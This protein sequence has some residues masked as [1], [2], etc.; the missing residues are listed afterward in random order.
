MGDNLREGLEGL[1]KIEGLSDILYV[2]IYWT[3]VVFVLLFTAY[4]I[5]ALSCYINRKRGRGGDIDED[6]F[7]D[8]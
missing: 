4:L 2:A 5:V 3:A 1:S 8:D 6:D 7:L